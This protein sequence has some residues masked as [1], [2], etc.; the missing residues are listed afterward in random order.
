[1][2]LPSPE[3]NVLRDLTVSP[4]QAEFTKSSVRRAELAP[5]IG[6]P[7]VDITALAPENNRDR[8]TEVFKVERDPETYEVHVESDITLEDYRQLMR[9]ED[10]NLMQ[11]YASQFEGKS[12]TFINPTMAGGGVAMMRPPLLHLLKLQGIEAHWFVMN[13][14]NNPD[15]PDPFVFTKKM[16]NILQRR[17][18]PDQHITEDG[19]NI[20]QAWVSDNADVLIKQPALQNTDVI[21]IDDPQPSPLIPRLKAVNPGA[22]IVWRNHIDNDGQ[23]MS[24]PSTPQ[25]EVWQYIKN[26]CGVEQADAYVFHPIDQ[27]VPA[28]IWN[29]T[30]FLPATIEPHDDMNRILS[31]A[32]IADGVNFINQ[33]IAEQNQRFVD[34][35]RYDEQQSLLDPDR[36]R[37]ALVARFD[38][39]KGMDKAIALG[40]RARQ[41]MLET[42]VTEE[43]LP[44]VVIVGNGSV[45]DPS[46]IPMY[47]EILAVKRN[48]TES[49]RKDIILARLDHNYQAI[50]ALMYASDI[51]M[52]TS[53][54]EGL[55]T[56]V[57]DWIRHGVPVVVSNRG[58]IKLQ[59]TPESGYIMDF[60]APDYDIDNGAN[61]ICRLMTNPNE[62]ARVRADTLEKSRDMNEREFTTSANTIR[63]LRL[64][65]NLLENKPADKVW[66][67]GD[68]VT[69]TEI[70]VVA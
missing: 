23:L 56:R 46:G 33:A 36:R 11:D 35:G 7:V 3:I 40:V 8:S 62:Y 55:E 37:I 70:E 63:W 52:Q 54:A 68:L 20:H 24:D 44:E 47:E 14:Q 32:E 25:G 18:A 5:L 64:F 21:V 30:Y 1:M 48:Y 31:E 53:E 61:Y 28:D 51:G 26:D 43:N 17:M 49:A 16:H 59:V 29:E 15:Q 41:K 10:W 58:G 42:G 9:P 27:F 45:D 69:S 39:S 22:K 60:D 12:V 65:K 66:K 19:K 50:N 2:A 57:S 13:G 38:E 67:I 34:Q 4:E 6:A